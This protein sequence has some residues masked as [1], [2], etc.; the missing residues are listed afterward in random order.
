MPRVTVE[1]VLQERARRQAAGPGIPSF[2]SGPSQAEEAS[3]PTPLG[4]AGGAL[5]QAATQAGV[6]TLQAGSQLATG[7]SLEQAQRAPF[8]AL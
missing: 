1:Q 7:Q 6:S 3:G 8:H 5:G 2:L 4:M